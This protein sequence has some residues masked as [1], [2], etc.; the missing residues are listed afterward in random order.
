MAKRPRAGRSKRNNIRGGKPRRPTALP[1]EY[2]AVTHMPG[3]P[4]TAPPQVM[5][6][7]QRPPPPLPMMVSDE[8]TGDV[9]ALLD[10]T[11]GEPVEVTPDL[12]PGDAR[13][14]IKKLTNFAAELKTE[15]SS[16]HVMFDDADA[17][18]EV[19]S[20]GRQRI[21]A[22]RDELFRRF[23]GLGGPQVDKVATAWTDVLLKVL[24]PIELEVDDWRADTQ[25]LIPAWRERFSSD[26]DGEPLTVSFHLVSSYTLHPSMAAKELEETTLPGAIKN[27]LDLVDWDIKSDLPPLELTGEQRK[28]LKEQKA[29]LHEALADL[30]AV[31]RAHYLHAYHRA[32]AAVAGDNISPRADRRAL[33]QSPLKKY[34]LK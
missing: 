15:Y 11:F 26:K 18:A 25:C 14:L 33:A 3:A 29:M 7:K 34:C 22:R 12:S 28:T 23:E 16:H 6:K 4:V 19:A 30:P 1:R 2:A 5:K 21:L 27:I 13:K 24:G 10:E 17:L 31:Q 9:P 8:P 32:L 20:D